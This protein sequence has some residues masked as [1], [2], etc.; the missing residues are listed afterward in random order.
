M[1]SIILNFLCVAGILSLVILY[2]KFWIDIQMQ[3][4]NFSDSVSEIKKT[5]FDISEEI[6]E[7][8]TKERKLDYDFDAAQR[9]AQEINKMN[10]GIVQIFSYDGSPSKKRMGDNE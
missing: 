9:A 10:E 7:L 6:K 8:I 3:N 5:Q 4:K 2:F 1:V